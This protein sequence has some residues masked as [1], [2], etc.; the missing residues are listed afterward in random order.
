MEL[1]SWILFSGVIQIL[2]EEYRGSIVHY[3]IHP[4]VILSSA[5]IVWISGTWVSVAIL[6]IPL[7][8]WIHFICEMEIEDEKLD[9]PAVILKPNEEGE[10]VDKLFLSKASK[11]R[12]KSRGEKFQ[13]LEIIFGDYLQEF[14][15]SNNPE[16]LNITIA[17]LWVNLKA[18]VEDYGLNLLWPQIHKEIKK[19]QSFANISLWDLDLGMVAP[20]IQKIQIHEN[21]KD[22]DKLVIDVTFVWA[23][24]SSAELRVLT[25]TGI[26]PLDAKINSILVKLKIRIALCGLMKEMPLV[27]ALEV[28]LLERPTIMWKAGGV[29]SVANAGAIKK[30]INKEMKKHLEP[31]IYPRKLTIPLT[32]LPLPPTIM[33]QVSNPQEFMDTVVPTPHGILSVWVKSGRDMIESDWGTSLADPLSFFKGPLEWLRKIP[34]KKRSSDPFAKVEVGSAF[35]DSKINLESLNPDFDLECHIPLEFPQGNYLQVKVF[36]WDKFKPNDLIGYRDEDL[37]F[38]SNVRCKMSEDGT[39]HCDMPNAHDHD[40]ESTEEEKNLSWRGLVGVNKGAV[41]MDYLWQPVNEITSDDPENFVKQKKGVLSFAIQ[42]L[43]LDVDTGCEGQC[44]PMIQLRILREEEEEGEKPAGSEISNIDNWKAMVPGKLSK[45]YKLGLMDAKTMDIFLLNGGML[46]FY[47][48]DDTIEI[49]VTI[50]VIKGIGNEVKT[51]TKQFS[52]RDAIHMSLADEVPR[53]ELDKQGTKKKDFIKGTW[54]SMQATMRGMKTTKIDT[55]M[56]TDMMKPP[57]DDNAAAD[58]TMR[59]KVFTV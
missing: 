59:F 21:E 5:T 27:K 24:E 19:S 46:S 23:S 2:W 50:Q 35:K 33:E 14:V 7:S 42:G 1:K 17:K 6:M 56:M 38:L 53:I 13:D 10:F 20:R 28:N 52:V 55:K 47:D 26:W 15:P 22:D 43:N 51:W 36:D 12:K 9:V 57:K 39:I 11:Y 54:K 25:G 34:P 4:M 3:L 31:F 44:R 29:G 40:A 45:S 37:N 49:E 32:C 18:A 48:I 58:I 16:W 8:F 41:F 30:L